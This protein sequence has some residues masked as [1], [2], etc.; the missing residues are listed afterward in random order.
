MAKANH[1]KTASCT[2]ILKKKKKKRVLPW[3]SKQSVS[4]PVCLK[5]V[6][7]SFMLE[8]YSSVLRM[9]SGLSV[10]NE[11]FEEIHCDFKW[12]NENICT[13]IIIDLQ[14]MQKAQ[15]TNTNYL[16][17][18]SSRPS[19]PFLECPATLLKLLLKERPPSHRSHLGHITEKS[20]T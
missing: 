3:V 18:I 19:R 14:R 11:T 7:N 20:R 4:Y 8:S 16:S 10:T 5:T 17:P 13:E 2:S 1:R 15:R 6:E 12:I 9:T